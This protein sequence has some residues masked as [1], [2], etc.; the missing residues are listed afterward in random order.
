MNLSSIEKDKFI[1][2]QVYIFQKDSASFPRSLY[3]NQNYK[4]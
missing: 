1:I 2:D 3:I 4:N